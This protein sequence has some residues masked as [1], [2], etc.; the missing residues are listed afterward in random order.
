[1][2]KTL[3]NIGMLNDQTNYVMLAV[4]LVLFIL[5]F[6]VVAFFIY[7]KTKRRKTLLISAIYLLS[8]IAAC[9][10]QLEL[11]KFGLLFLGVFFVI[12]FFPF[13]KKFDR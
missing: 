9:I 10:L 3:I 5:I 2:L 12:V 7:K 6:A 8:G 4:E 13:T 1:M 11:F